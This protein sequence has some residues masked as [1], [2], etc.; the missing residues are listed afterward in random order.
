MLLRLNVKN[1]A[2]L[3]QLELVFPCGFAALT[4]ETGAGKSLVLDALGLLLGARADASLIRH[5]EPLAE[6]IGV[7]RPSFTPDLANLLE[8]QGLNLE[9]HELNIRR[10]IKREGGGKAWANGVA[11]PLAWLAS[12][13]ECLAEV[14]AQ[15][16]APALLQPSHQR[17]VLDAAGSL[18][19]FT[20][21][22]VQSFTAWQIAKVEAEAAT[23]AL[24]QA[25]A[26]QET[27]RENL[28]LLERTAYTAGEEDQ[29]AAQRTRL[30]FGAQLNGHLQAAD[31]ALNAERGAVQALRIA[32]KQL[33]HAAK[34]DEA[35][36]PLAGQLQ[37]AL[38]VAEDAAHSVAKGAAAGEGEGNL[39]VLDDRLHALKTA[40][41]RVGCSVPE[42]GTKQAE[43][44]ALLADSSALATAANR[45]AKAAAEARAAFETACQALTQARRAAAATL[46]PQLQT[47]LRALLLPHAEVAVDFTPLPPSSW[48][49][50]GAE[51]VQILLAANPGSPAQPIQKVASGGEL[52]RLLLALKQVFYA[53]LPPQVLVLDEVD[54]GLSGAAASAVGAAMAA[55]G[56]RHQVLAVTHHAQ[57][58][59]RAAAHGKLFK[60]VQN[61]A[62]TTQL[63]WLQGPA[64]LEELAR[65]LAGENITN[66]ARAAAQALL[67]E[68]QGKKKAA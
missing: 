57:V 16:S 58:A 60:Q 54:T 24:T 36:A 44:Q 3:A 47:A 62:T 52:A 10:Q 27:A 66:E 31:D 42:L 20:T 32:S 63:N 46:V 8:E 6:V 61:G 21:A 43:L 40:A 14:Q 53:N 2:L 30:Q 37:E 41:R 45:T 1:L 33:Q 11:V 19:T 34:I 55:L 59:V 38:A 29:L 13:G 35:L 23:A 28:A 7:F 17:T 67:A 65:L 49:G 25:E 26:L 50:Q 48:N 5:G 22:T 12:V 39:E 15:H 9:D 51:S 56:T 68:A 4:G 18:A 64:R